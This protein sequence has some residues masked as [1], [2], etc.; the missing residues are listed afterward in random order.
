MCFKGS[1]NNYKSL[2]DRFFASM[3]VDLG[4]LLACMFLIQGLSGC[5]ALGL[6]EDE[7]GRPTVTIPALRFGDEWS[8]VSI[9]D[10]KVVPGSSLRTRVGLAPETTLDRFGD[11]VSALRVEKIGSGDHVRTS[12]MELEGGNWLK[13]DSFGRGLIETCSYPV[14]SGQTGMQRRESAPREE[15]YPP[16]PVRA[17]AGEVWGKTFQPGSKVYETAW[18]DM[19]QFSFVENYEYK[20]LGRATIRPLVTGGDPLETVVI[21]RSTFGNQ[22]SPQSSDEWRS[23]EQYFVHEAYPA[24]LRIQMVEG[25]D[26]RITQELES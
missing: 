17:N 10:D 20:V 11:P 26:V 3:T 6:S 24:P 18:F 8:L 9:S 19:F 4:R 7:Q 5:T 25:K 22:V 2:R 14:L 1:T 16:W 12:F 15:R 21:E 13:H 23:K